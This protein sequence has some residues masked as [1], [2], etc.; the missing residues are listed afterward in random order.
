[1][2]HYGQLKMEGDERQKL[3]FKDHMDNLKSGPDGKDRIERESRFI[4]RKIEEVETE[5][6]TIEGSMGMFNFKSK[7]GEAMKLDIENKIQKLERDI[8]RLKGQHKEL[9]KELRE[10]QA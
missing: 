10:Q 7:A 4:K 2:K 1:E 6:R 3:R 5:K 9:M 8:E